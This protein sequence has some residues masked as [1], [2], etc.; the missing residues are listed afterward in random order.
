MRQQVAFEAVCTELDDVGHIGRQ[1]HL[2]AFEHGELF[3]RIRLDQPQLHR[4]IPRGVAVQKCREQPLDR[5]R[6]S[7]DAQHRNIPTPQRLRPLV[8]DCRVT[9]HV[10]A[11]LEEM[12]PTRRQHQAASDP[13][14]QLEAELVLQPGDLSRQRRLRNVQQLRGFRNRPTL[15]HGHEGTELLEVHRQ[16][17]C[18]FGME[19]HANNALDYRQLGGAREPRS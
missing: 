19:N 9:Q 8:K 1:V 6:G 3:D 17:L 18:H 11:I 14:E 16:C 10:P 4:G 5:L 2:A 12:L 15:R 7:R 13:L